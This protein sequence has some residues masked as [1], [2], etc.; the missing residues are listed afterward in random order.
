M[1]KIIFNFDKAIKDELIYVPPNSIMFHYYVPNS[2]IF[3]FM[4]FIIQDLKQKMNLYIISPD[5]SLAGYD[6]LCL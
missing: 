6:N 4:L 3:H 2:I 1:I 5:L